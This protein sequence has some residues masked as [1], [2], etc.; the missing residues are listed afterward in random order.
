M[1]SRKKFITRSASVIT[2]CMLLREL[3]FTATPKVMSVNGYIAAGDMGFT[4]SHEHILVDFIGAAKVSPDRYSADEAFGIAWP[5]LIAAKES[6]CR[7]LVE[8]TPDWLGRDVKLLQRLSVETGL[9][10][11]TNTGYYGAA[12]EKFLPAHA[13]TE[14]AAQL[15]ER[16]ITEWENGIDG[17]GIRPGFIKSG[18]D[19]YPLSSVQEKIIEAAAIT[20]LATG[21][22]IG[23]HTGNG[24]AAWAELTILASK[25]VAPGAWIWIHAQNEKDHHWHIRVAKAGGWVSYDGVSEDTI[26]DC[27]SFL[28]RMKKETLLGKVLLSQDAGWYHVGEANGGNYRGY[29]TIAEKLLPAMKANGFTGADI[30]Q[31]FIHNA[32]MAFAI[33]VR[34]K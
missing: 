8:C 3:P 5:K 12:S 22:T 31:V 30:N 16:W 4:L 13:Y 6:G 21:L 34:K 26:G 32:A 28:K 11:L 18:I 9:N 17:T 14:T 25:G 15:A 24:P 33:G 27:L 1:I 19:S 10:I 23:V 7:T 20:H 2:G 29:N